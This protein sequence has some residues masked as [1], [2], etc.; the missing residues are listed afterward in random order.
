LKHIFIS[1]LPGSAGNF[2]TRFLQCATENS[3][4]WLNDVGVPDNIIDKTKLLEY[5]TIFNSKTN[6]IEFENQLKHFSKILDISSLHHNSTLIWPGHGL[7]LDKIK[8]KNIIGND[9]SYEFIQITYD[10]KEELE[11]ILLNAFYKDSFVD[12]SQFETYQRNIK[13]K[14]TR[15]FSVSNFL[16][17][18]SFS[19]NVLEILDQNKIDYNLENINE[20]QIFYN[21]WY[22]TTLKLSEFNNFKKSIGWLL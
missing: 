1:F 22:N 21:D 16:N 14:N 8:N 19:K 7:T 18:D 3:Y 4:C 2:L 9:D 5:K 12:R 13:E 11:W 10:T 20:L 15:F 17:W 6:W